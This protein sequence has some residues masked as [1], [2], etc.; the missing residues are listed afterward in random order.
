[1][2]WVAKAL[3]QAVRPVEWW[4]SGIKDER[5]SISGSGTYNE[6]LRLLDE[7]PSQYKTML[8]DKEGFTPIDDYQKESD[9]QISIRQT[10]M[11]A[12]REWA[13][14]TLD[15]MALAEATNETDKVA[16]EALGQIIT[17]YDSWERTT[18]YH[19]KLLSGRGR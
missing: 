7:I 11:L 17:R 3:K 18:N 9:D 16:A 14:H 8:I 13:R 15:E 5:L 2:N 19:D 1:M 4:I 6:M 10:R 12:L